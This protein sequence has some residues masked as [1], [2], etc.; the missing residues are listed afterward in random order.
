IVPLGAGQD[1]GRSC[2]LVT[3][4]G[5]NVM[6]DCGMHMGYQD[7]RRFPDF[8]Y[9]G[10][11]GKLNDYLTCVIISHFHLDHCGSLPHM[12]EIVGFDG[13]IYM[14]YPTK[15]IAPV[16]LE[17][18]RKVQTEFRG[19]TNFFTSANIKACMKKVIAV[20]LHETVQVDSELS[21]RAF[22]AGH[23]LGAAMFEI[24]VG[25]QS[26]LYTGDYNMTPDRHLGAARVLP[27]LRPDCLISE[28][29]YATT[30]RDSKRA[31][32]RDFLRK[33]HDRVMAG[34][35]VL[36][37]VFALGRAQEL[38]ILL[39]SYWERMDLKIPIYF[40]Q[41]LA[42]R[43][44]QYYRLF[45]NWTNEKIKRTFVERN[46]F[47]FKHIKP[48]D[49]GY[50]E[51]PGAMVLFSTPGYC[52]A[53]TVG[54]KVISGMKKIEI[55]GKMHDINLAVEYM[56]FSAHADAKGIMQLIRVC[57]PRSV[58][59]VHGE[60]AKMEFLK[61]KVEKE[62]RVPVLMPANGESVSI[63][64]ISILEVDVPQDIVQR[65][66][67]LDPTPSKKAC[68]FSAC[69]VMDKQNG[70]EVI[71][72]EAA[73]SRLQLGLHTIT[74][75][76]L[77]KSRSVVDWRALSEALSIHDTHL[78]HKQDGIELFHGEICVLPVKGDDN[79]ASD[80]NHWA[81]YIGR[82]DGL[83]LVVHLSGGDGD[84]GKISGS[85]LDSLSNGPSGVLKACTAQVRCDPLL[86][87]AG[88]NLVRINNAHDIDHQPFPPR[89][90]VERATLQLGSGNYNIFLN[91]CEHFVK[92]C[93]YGNRI[94]GQ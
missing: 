71:S 89:I 81:V 84:F 65:C 34:G 59:F 15:A 87:V 17:D 92:W 83:P 28:S 24:R 80:K 88:E 82:H 93:R 36:I 42:E 9:I 4:G 53:G 32:E 46:M 52:V 31:R 58:M 86:A 38:C 10:G 55:E 27:G 22:Y 64:G 5:K 13:P 49:K 29:T 73:A 72:C 75:S 25:H 94:S 51:M 68:P 45:I 11:G 40:S 26:I 74:L 16:L 6:L 47:D 48:L 50:E 79:Q 44:N 90:V 18:Y 91:N 30:I 2:I 19:D 37:P 21:I 56:S 7:E 85:T 20:D 61:G 12:S 3:I 60:A 23:V 77:V 33:V 14:T 66:L 39:E 78:Q 69:L 62:F 8:S 67:D 54:A 57:Q 43:A 70:L 35:K 1:V 41:G 63:P 76:Q